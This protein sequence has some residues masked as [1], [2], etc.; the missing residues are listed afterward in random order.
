MVGFAVGSLAKRNYNRMGLLLYS[1]SLTFAHI[2]L[3]AMDR[4]ILLS[5]LSALCLQKVEQ[6]ES[7]VSVAYFCN[8]W[9]HHIE[10][11]RVWILTSDKPEFRHGS[12]TICVVL[13]RS[14]KL[15]KLDYYNL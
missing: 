10:K 13:G 8:L 1:S 9:R 4:E 7:H 12:L 3:G 11:L 6:S 2:C 14:R 15:S 5:L